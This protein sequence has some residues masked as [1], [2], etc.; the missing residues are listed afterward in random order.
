[1]Q[2]PVFLHFKDTLF[3]APLFV[4]PLGN[5]ALRRHRAAEEREAEERGVYLLYDALRRHLPLRIP[6]PK[7]GVKKRE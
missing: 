3:S 1:M 6:L 5:D 7:K 4:P 2:W